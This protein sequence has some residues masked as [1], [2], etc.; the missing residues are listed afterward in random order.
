[1]LG[2]LLLLTSVVACSWNIREWTGVAL[3]CG[4]WHPLL[5]YFLLAQQQVLPPS[6]RFF[7]WLYSTAEKYRLQ[8]EIG[9][10]DCSDM[11]T[12]CKLHHS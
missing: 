5:D 1:M 11:D 12:S 9:R 10:T 6:Y 7:S 3:Y 2:S 8:R 4:N